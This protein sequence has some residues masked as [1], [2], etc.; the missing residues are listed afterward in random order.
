MPDVMSTMKRA[1]STVTSSQAATVVRLSASQNWIERDTALCC[2]DRWA[3]VGVDTDANG[4][5]SSSKRGPE[6]STERSIVIVCGELRSQG[7]ATGFG[8]WKTR[9]AIRRALKRTT[10][11]V[12]SQTVIWDYYGPSTQRPD[13]YVKYSP[14]NHQFLVFAS[15][16]SYFE[17]QPST[18]RART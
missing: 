6:L 15:F 14:Y 2:S 13:R 10:G 1:L 5:F 4:Q 16:P 8:R 18:F 3:N 9:W 17:F 11:C 7:E 12:R